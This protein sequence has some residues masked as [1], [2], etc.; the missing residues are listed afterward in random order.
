[1]RSCCRVDVACCLCCLHFHNDL[2]G[3]TARTHPVD[4]R[5][6]T[7]QLLNVFNCVL[8]LLSA[9]SIVLSGKHLVTQSLHVSP[10]QT[11][12]LVG[13]FPL[14]FSP[15]IVKPYGLSRCIYLGYKDFLFC[16]NHQT[17]QCIRRQKPV[18]SIFNPWLASKIANFHGYTVGFIVWRTK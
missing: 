12:S 6:V 7:D 14:A 1:V 13:Q 8:W 5:K 3:K 4:E 17:Q 18:F 11:P 10:C 9:G 2:L 16:E 15:S